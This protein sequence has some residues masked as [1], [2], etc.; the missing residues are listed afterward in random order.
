MIIESLVLGI[1][2]GFPKFRVDIL[3]LHRSTV[4]VEVLANHHTVGTVYLGSLTAYRIL[5]LTIAWRLAKQ[6]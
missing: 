4:F 6:P 5:Y 2:E 3:I 1:Y